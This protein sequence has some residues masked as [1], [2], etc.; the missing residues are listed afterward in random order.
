MHTYLAQVILREQTTGVD[1][2][3]GSSNPFGDQQLKVCPPS[4]PPRARTVPQRSFTSECLGSQ[5]VC[6]HQMPVTELKRLRKAEGAVPVLHRALC[7]RSSSQNVHCRP[8]AAAP[9]GTWQGSVSPFQATAFQ[10][11]SC[12]TAVLRWTTSVGN[13]LTETILTR[14]SE[15]N[16]HY[17]A[18]TENASHR[19]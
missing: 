16:Q 9:R 2:V 10:Q 12:R 14:A 4:L 3:S 18:R 11:L 19:T 17:C 15:Q 8:F 1:S 6:T 5:S 7:A 13:F